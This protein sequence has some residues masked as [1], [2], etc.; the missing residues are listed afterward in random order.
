MMRQNLVASY[1]AN[2]NKKSQLKIQEMAFMLIGVF[3]FF[4]LVGLLMLSIFYQ[5][6]KK[7][8][9][10]IKESRTLSLIT[11]LADSPEFSCVSSKSNCV[12]ADKV[13][14][15]VNKTSYGNFWPFTSLK[16][17]RSR[18]FNKKE[19]DMIQCNMANYNECSN[20]YKTS[21]GFSPE[22]QKIFNSKG[23]IELD[24]YL[25]KNPSIISPSSGSGSTSKNTN[26]NLISG[27]Y[28]A[29]NTGESA[30]IIAISSPTDF[31]TGDKLSIVNLEGIFTDPG[32]RDNADCST[33]TG[34][35]GGMSTALGKFYKG[36]IRVSAEYELKDMQNIAI[37]SNADRLIVYFK[38]DSLKDNIGGCSFDVQIESSKTITNPEITSPINTVEYANEDDINYTNVYDYELEQKCYNEIMG[39]CDPD[40]DI[41]TIY[42]KKIENER[43]ISSFV[44]LCRKE[45]ENGYT[46]DRCEIA[47]LVAGTE[48]KQ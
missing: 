48:I 11:S 1:L 44:A 21:I 30:R 27:K 13:I 4:V 3:L 42:D 32:D 37:P 43:T 39:L 20:S 26:I 15:L 35:K 18:A 12:D 24:P 9:I 34:I 5:N 23:G 40:C 47:K 36:N 28:I 38:D 41:F 14:S 17:V 29:S 33:A 7:E 45:Y 22:C 46:Y 10:Q 6:L 8:S 31:S 25:G 2:M 19:S 16:V